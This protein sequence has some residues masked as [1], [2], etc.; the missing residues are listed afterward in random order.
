M[1]NTLDRIENA[2]KDRQ[3]ETTSKSL[4]IHFLLF[5]NKAAIVRCYELNIELKTFYSHRKKLIENEYM[6]SH[7][8]DNIEL[9]K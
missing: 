1:K 2:L 4:Y 9:I 7:G 3:L 5:P 6:L 8:K